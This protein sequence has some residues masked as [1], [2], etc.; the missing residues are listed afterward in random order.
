MKIIKYNKLK[1]IYPVVLVVL[2][3]IS[4]FIVL[5]KTTDNDEEKLRELINKMDNQVKPSE[6]VTI[7]APATPSSIPI[8]IASQHLSD[9]EVKI[10]I[11][12]NQ[13]HALFLRGD[14]QILCTGLSV[15]VSFYDQGEDIQILNSY[16][17]GL[18]YLLSYGKEIESFGQLKGE[19]VYVPFK[20]APLEQITKYFV[21]QEGLEWEKDVTPIYTIP[22]ITTELFKKGD[23]IIAPLPEPLVSI[24]KNDP[25]IHLSLD[26]KKQWEKYTDNTEGYPQIGTFVKTDW[27]H[28]NKEYIYKFDKEII[29]AIELI[30]DN[31]TKAIELSKDSFE[32][33]DK[34]LMSAL[35]NTFFKNVI[36]YDLQKQITDYYETISQPLDKKFENFFFIY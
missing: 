18:S 9:T 16:V 8:I 33:S 35:E 15:G 26:Y 20:G 4:L 36:S 5:Y 32:F 31:P 17:Q 34:I 13:A 12:H 3:S 14:V 30:K 1:Y 25:N 6:P 21:E 28:D 22:T 27:I 11:D 2:L 23:H 24:L 29:K 7:Y 19:K 10:F